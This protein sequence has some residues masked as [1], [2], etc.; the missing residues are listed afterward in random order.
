MRSG[1]LR[2][3][4]SLFKGRLFIIVW[5]TRFFCALWFVSIL[6]SGDGIPVLYLHLD[7]QQSMLLAELSTACFDVEALVASDVGLSLVSS[8]RTARAFW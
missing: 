1:R 5:I 6:S 3:D 7:G 8:T 2:L 4:V